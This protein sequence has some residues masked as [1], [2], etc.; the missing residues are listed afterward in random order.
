[1]TNFEASGG[2]LPRLPYLARNEGEPKD[3]DWHFDVY[4]YFSDDAILKNDCT[5][6]A[7]SPNR[8]QF[9]TS[10]GQQIVKH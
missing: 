6:S 7:F 1:M 2:S 3:F 9:I 4:S 8:S 10:G 5:A